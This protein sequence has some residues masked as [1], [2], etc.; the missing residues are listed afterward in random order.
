MTAIHIFTILLF[1][2]SPLLSCESEKVQSRQS[3]PSNDVEDNPG[4]LDTIETDVTS[5]EESEVSIGSTTIRIPKDSASSNYRVRISRLAAPSL[6]EAET[7][8]LGDAESD[9]VAVEVFDPSSNKTLAS[10]D[11]LAPYEFQQS[12]KSAA[13]PSRIGLMVVSGQDRTLI[14][15]SELSV[16]TGT[17]LSLVST[18]DL[19]VRVKLRVTMATMWLVTYQDDAIKNLVTS[20]ADALSTSGGSATTAVIIKSSGTISGTAVSIESDAAYTTTS[21]VTLSLNAANAS[22]MYITNSS[23]CKTG[24]EWE[25]FSATKSW[26]LGGVNSVSRVYVR[27]RATD[28]STSSCVSDSITH[29]DIPPAAPTSMLDDTTSSSLTTSP[30]MSWTASTNADLSHYQ[31]A[32]GTFQGGTDIKTWTSIGNVTSASVGGLSLSDGATYYGSVRAVDLA[33]LMSSTAE[34]NGWTVSTSTL[35]CPGPQPPAEPTWV[36]V[37]ANTQLST[38]E[39]CVMKYEAKSVSNTATSQTALTPWVNISRA[40]AITKCQALGAGYDLITNAQWQAIARNIESVPSN[41]S[42]GSLTGNVN[43]GNS[44]NRGHSDNS[45]AFSPANAL[46]ASTDD[47]PCFGTSNNSCTTGSHADF[48]QKRTHRLSNGAV[49]WDIGGNVWEWVKDNNN[50]AQGADKYVSQLD[51]S[52]DLLNWGAA[53]NYSAKADGE[54]GGLGYGNLN[55]SSGAVQRGGDWLN[56]TFAGVFAAGSGYDPASTFGSVGFRCSA[57]GGL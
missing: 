5:S 26:T 53:G 29:D 52:D 21:E 35:T 37:P 30:T 9:V 31:V 11:L 22:E 50:S 2:L 6:T 44:I 10:S 39:F 32:V 18:T 20:T 56:L 7:L 17:A 14:P 28:G 43:D 40:D 49:I 55:V 16:S 8:V 13:A 36:K 33:G 12:F 46:A 47:L 25:T 57:V 48:S 4:F 27:Y 41:W 45:P 38:A 34:A 42:A 54:R 23:G 1:S 15:N 19:T 3:R 51:G 24:G